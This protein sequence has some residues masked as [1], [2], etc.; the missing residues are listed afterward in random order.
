VFLIESTTELIVAVEL[1]QPTT[2]TFRFPAV[3]A[4][5]YTTVTDVGELCGVALFP[6]T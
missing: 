1:F 4:S 3:C 2:T 6:C 5:V